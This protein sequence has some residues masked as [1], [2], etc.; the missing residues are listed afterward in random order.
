M[1]NVI[2]CRGP[3]HNLSKFPQFA[4]NKKVYE[5]LPDVNFKEMISNDPDIRFIE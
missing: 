2:L 3:T 1:A 5:H 4:P